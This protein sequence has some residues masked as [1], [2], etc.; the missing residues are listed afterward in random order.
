MT[1]TAAAAAMGANVPLVGITKGEARARWDNDQLVGVSTTFYAAGWTGATMRPSAWRGLFPTFDEMVAASIDSRRPSAL[2]FWRP[3][4][5]DMNDSN[6]LG[7]GPGHD[8]GSNTMTETT[9][10]ELHRPEPLEG[11]R[12]ARVALDISTYDGLL[13]AGLLWNGFECPAFPRDEVERMM[14]EF[15]KLA[16]NPDTLVDTLRWSADNP[17]VLEIVSSQYNAAG[18]ELREGDEPAVDRLEPGVQ[19]LYH[20]GGWSWCWGVVAHE[21]VLTPGTTNPAMSH[22]SC[23]CG[24]WS[25]DASHGHG[26]EY[27]RDKYNREHFDVIY[28]PVTN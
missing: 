1:E 12:W 2:Y 22:G 10:V 6:A 18:D 24:R 15:N 27:V 20:V 8:E 7:T 26:S 28:P 13:T 9:A 11:Q 21:L 17:D 16:E 25:T 19:G 3:A 23:I 5:E 14:A 4:V